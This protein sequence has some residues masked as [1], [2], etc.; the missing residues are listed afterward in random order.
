VKRKL[1]RRQFREYER[2]SKRKKQKIEELNSLC[3]T[4]TNDE[5]ESK[6]GEEN[7]FGRWE[8]GVSS[9][10]VD[11]LDSSNP[12]TNLPLP[13]IPSEENGEER[14]YLSVHNQADNLGGNL[15]LN[16]KKID[17][18]FHLYLDI[19]ISFNDLKKIL[20]YI[21]SGMFGEGVSV[22][23]Q[24]IL[25]KGIVVQKKKNPVVRSI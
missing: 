3:Q 2:E 19:D 23:P 16:E 15:T 11:E 24:K 17:G 14:E 13:Q 12:Q 7:L 21:N 8:E 6:G 20:E 22:S 18:L 5:I 1:H 4:T 9:E 10:V 25:E